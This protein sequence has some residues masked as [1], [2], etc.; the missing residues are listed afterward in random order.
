[1]NKM[2]IGLTLVSTIA[3]QAQTT[4]TTAPAAPATQTSTITTTDAKPAA[5]S[6]YGAIVYVESSAGIQS[7]KDNGSATPISTFYTLGLNYKTGKMKYE[8]AQHAQSRTNQNNL[9]GSEATVFTKDTSTTTATD[10][11]GNFVLTYPYLKGTYSSEQRLLNSEP[12]AFSLRYYLPIS[13]F[14]H[15]SRVKS[16]GAFRADINPSWVLNPKWTLDFVFSPRVNLYLEGATHGTDPRYRIVSGPSMTY[17]V[18]DVFN[19]YYIPYVDLR[20]YD[21]G[22][23]TLAVEAGK[24]MAHEVG[25]NIVVGKVTINPMIDTSNSLDGGGAGIF[26]DGSRVFAADTTNYNLNIYASF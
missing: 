1:M 26:T 9:E 23:G 12:L 4:S 14:D 18:S 3:A 16:N 5:A 24:D 15:D 2:L 25:L 13:A 21:V 11:R 20:S 19:A 6:P 7:A 17:N 8:L 10:S 22:R